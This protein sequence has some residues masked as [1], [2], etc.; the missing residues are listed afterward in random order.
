MPSFT[1]YTS[2]EHNKEL[3]EALLSRINI[4]ALGS[5]PSYD[6]DVWRY[7]VLPKSGMFIRAWPFTSGKSFE[8]T[9][10][11]IPCIYL[12]PSLEALGEFVKGL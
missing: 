5:Y 2:P 11:H 10:E 12:M 9:R 6:S 4:D 7:K 3:Y 8:I 1:L